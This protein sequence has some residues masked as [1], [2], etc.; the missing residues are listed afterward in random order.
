MSLATNGAARTLRQDR[1]FRFFQTSM[2]PPA[3]GQ[4]R[5]E[6]GA[7][8]PVGSLSRRLRPDPQAIHSV[9]APVLR[10]GIVDAFVKTCQRWGLAEP[11]QIILLGYGTNPFLGHEILNGR[12]LSPPQDVKDRVGFVLGISLGLGSV[13]DESVQAELAWL[14]K[15]HARLGTQTPLEFMLQGRMV[16]LATV[17]GLVAE[18]RAL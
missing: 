13:F 1:D 2:Q 18:E 8:V 6:P 4:L 10:R 14:N 16:N 5:G 7:F 12:W 15:R 11:Q 3:G 17:A 9:Q